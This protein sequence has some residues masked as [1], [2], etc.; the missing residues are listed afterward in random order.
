[1]MNSVTKWMLAVATMA[2]AAGSASAQTYTAEIPFA[3][4]AGGS[5]MAPGKYQL[6]V[7]GSTSI[8]TP[9]LRNLDTNKGILLAAYPQGAISANGVSKF[10][11]ECAEGSCVL[12]QLWRGD[13][14]NVY[15]FMGPKPGHGDDARITEITLTSVKAN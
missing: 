4:R 9:V 14:G 11:F 1:M 15:K 12:R 13:S 6:S 7:G 2:I 3:F 5:M 8:P 10:V